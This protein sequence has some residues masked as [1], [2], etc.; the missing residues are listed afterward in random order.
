MNTHTRARNL[1][2]EAS[3]KHKHHGDFRSLSREEH[4]KRFMHHNDEAD[5]LGSSHPD[6]NHH[7]TLAS[8][9]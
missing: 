6:Y 4:D 3:K 2:D 1:Y 5:R 7:M 9:I 8:I